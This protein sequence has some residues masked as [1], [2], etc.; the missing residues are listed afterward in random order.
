MLPGFV[1]AHSHFSAMMQMAGGLDL[2]DPS[3]PTVTDIPSLQA[4]IRA[5]IDARAIPA[6]G[7]LV[8]WP[9]DNEALHEKRHIT[10]AELDAGTPARKN[11]VLHRPLRK[12]KGPRP[13]YST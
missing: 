1:D 12:R 7:W 8:V 11:A 6:R 3:L 4:A 2:D 10:R 5:L 13:K 9:Y